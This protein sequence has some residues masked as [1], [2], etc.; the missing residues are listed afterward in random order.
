MILYAIKIF[1][2]MV[3]YLY[4]GFF[5]TPKPNKLFTKDVFGGGYF[6]SFLVYGIFGVGGWLLLLGFCVNPISKGSF[7]GIFKGF[8]VFCWFGLV[9]CGRFGCGFITILFCCFFKYYKKYISWFLSIIYCI[10]RIINWIICIIRIIYIIC[11]ICY[12]KELKIWF[13]RLRIERIVCIVYIFRKYI[14]ICSIIIL[15]NII[16]NFSII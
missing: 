9:C 16:L 10:R 8:T 13:I 7:L 6:E 14:L 5:P 2:F 11:I 1:I 3:W 4:Q 12:T 15:R